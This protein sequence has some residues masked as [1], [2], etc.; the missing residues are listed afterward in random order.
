MQCHAKRFIH[1]RLF[2]FLPKDSEHSY[3]PLNFK[4]ISSVLFRVRKL[5]RDQIDYVASILVQCPMQKGLFER[6]FTEFYRKTANVFCLQL[7]G[8]LCTNTHRQRSVEESRKLHATS[9]FVC[10]P[11][12]HPPQRKGVTR[13]MWLALAQTFSNN[14]CLRLCATLRD[15]ARLCATLRV[16]YPYTQTPTRQPARLSNPFKHPFNAA[17]QIGAVPVG[18]LGTGRCVYMTVLGSVGP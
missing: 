18:A 12:S 4:Y 13:L 5:P 8:L 6:G 10:L 15:S 9:F 7:K 3:F 11:L 16:V 2:D 1:K 14:T 17:F